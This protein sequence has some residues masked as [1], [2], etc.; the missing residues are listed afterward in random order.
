MNGKLYFTTSRHSNFEY[1]HELLNRFL[2]V[3]ESVSAEKNY[4]NQL[5]SA[6][7]CDG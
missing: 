7:F 3:I 4:I 1:E 2:K 5:T 6:A